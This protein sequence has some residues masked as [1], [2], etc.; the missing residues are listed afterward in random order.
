MRA[1][2]E[3]EKRLIRIAA[4]LVS[5]YLL[6]FYGIRGLKSLEEKRSEYLQV[7]EEGEALKMKVL[8]EKLKA[9]RL[10]KLR[11]SLRIDLEGL[12]EDTVV[13][14]ASAAIQKAAQAQGIQLGPM[15]ETR[16][17]SLSKEI[18]SIQIEG[19][20][21]TQAAAQ[22]IASL[23]SIGYPLVLDSIHAKKNPQ[24]PA[25]VSFTLNVVVLNYGAWTQK[26]AE[27]KSV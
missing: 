4:V 12:R 25:R 10:R 2:T 8:S 17:R 1:L 14:E 20:G 13:G 3:R 5:A 6:L 23:K 16:G 21:A 26:A 9:E 27:K 22:F 11:E 19:Q 15:K 18:A 7:R 24:K